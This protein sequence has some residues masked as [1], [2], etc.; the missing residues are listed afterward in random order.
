MSEFSNDVRQRKL[1]KPTANGTAHRKI[2]IE[3]VNGADPFKYRV[4]TKNRT[5]SPTFGLRDPNDRKSPTADS[6]WKMDPPKLPRTTL[7]EAI[8]DAEKELKRSIDE[9][10]ELV[11]ADKDFPLL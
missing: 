4:T 3:D 6:T 5:Q 8:E 11:K 2:S 9:G 10:F 1:F 7:N